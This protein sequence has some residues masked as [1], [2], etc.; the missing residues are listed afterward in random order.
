MKISFTIRIRVFVALVS[1]VF[2]YNSELWSLSQKDS[3]RIDTFQRSFLRQIIRKRRIS[4]KELYK[5]CN[6][7]PWSTQIKRRRLTWFGHVN[8]LPDNAPAKLALAEARKPYKKVCGG[9][10]TSWLSTIAKDFK[11]VGKTISEYNKPIA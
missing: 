9:Q 5:V 7:E 10:K 4:N 8:R 1:S 3:V 11:K 6:I 2:L